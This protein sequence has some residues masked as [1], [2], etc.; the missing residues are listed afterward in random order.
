MLVPVVVFDSN[1][2]LPLTAKW[3]LSKVKIASLKAKAVLSF[4]QPVHQLE[5]KIKD[6][7]ATCQSGPDHKE[8]TLTFSRIKAG[9]YN[10][11][12]AADG[13]LITLDPL[14]IMSAIQNSDGDFDL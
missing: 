14:E 10:V 12:V 8:W 7:T 2:A 4:N 5:A 11:S 6:N 13:K 1:E 9:T 3:K